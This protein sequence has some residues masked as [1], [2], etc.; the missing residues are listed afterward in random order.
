[1]KET[2]FKA[3][4]SVVCGGLS[5]YFGV[6]GVPLAVLFAAMCIDYG[7]GMT[8]AWVTGEL[9]SRV[10]VLG[11]IKKVG[12]LTAVCVAGIIDWLLISG[13]KQVGISI[14]LSYFMG[15]M[16]TIWFIVNE[17]ISI[18]ENLST[19]GVPLPAFLV[20]MVHRLKVVV[21]EKGEEKEE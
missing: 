19:L 4:I 7:T 8:K 17:C 6:I 9:S 13:L 16:V 2:S 3:L 10:G 20:A 21:D 1:M 11:I 18:L 12:Y 14:G 5:A 15:L